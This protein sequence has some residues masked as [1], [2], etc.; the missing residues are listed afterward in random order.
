[1][2]NTN[3]IVDKDVEDFIISF[4]NSYYKSMKYL[5]SED[6]K[7][8][9]SSNSLK[10]YYIYQGS[11]DTLINSRKKQMNDLSLS[12]ASYDLTFDLI[13]YKDSEYKIDIIEDGYFNFNFMKKITSKTYNILNSFVLVKED[14]EYKIKSYYKEQGFYIMISNLIDE[15]LTDEETNEEVEKLVGKYNR[16][17][18]RMYEGILDDF[19]SY[20]NNKDLEFK[21][22]DNPYYGKKAAEFAKKHVTEET[23][24]YYGEYGGNC[25]NLA[26]WSLYE[27]GIPMDIN[28]YYIWKHYDS[29]LDEY[30]TK[31]GRT[32]SWTSSPY[33]YDYA[34]NN[35]GYGLCSEVDVNVFYGEVGDLALV[36]YNKEYSHSSVVIDLI[37][38]EDGNTIDLLIASNTGDA[39]DLPLSAYPYPLKSLIKIL[40]WNN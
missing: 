20:K 9:F 26:S 13:E 34:E 19:E 31:E 8:Y 15:D 21:T 24:Y 5:E 10:E 32:S 35:D 22:C 3:E 30:N 27:G 4:F 40:G 18:D 1:M 23:E 12:K 39:I 17:F 11:I 29:W 2:N 38:D 33:F 14:N 36:G 25:Q 16:Q 37:K 6:M 7:D 28:G